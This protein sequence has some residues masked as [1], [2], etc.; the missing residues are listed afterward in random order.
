MS[1]IAK[2]AICIPDNVKIDIKNQLVSIKGIKGEL[3]H[4]VHSSVQIQYINNSLI[5]ST[6]HESFHGWA[7]AGTARAI[8]NS[9]VI[10][11]SEGFIKKLQL[12]GVGYRVTLNNDVLILSL[13]FSHAIDYKLPLGITA[14]VLS[15]NEF[16]LKGS[17]KQLLN[18]VAANIRSYRRPEPYKGKGVKLDNEIIKLK[19]AKK[20]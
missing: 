19:E 12:V 18:Q 9:I 8:I 4:N 13:G 20:K 10:G 2:T 6:H 7:H 11:V 5:F 15:N 1:R 17:N 3:T 16:L 14:E